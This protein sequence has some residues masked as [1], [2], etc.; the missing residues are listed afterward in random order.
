MRKNVFSFK[1]LL[2]AA[3]VIYAMASIIVWVPQID[4]LLT[5]DYDVI[6]EHIS[7][8]DGWEVIRSFTMFPWMLSI[9]R[10]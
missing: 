4:R 2:K 7:L 9:F 5:K 3:W 1:N 10:Q 6:S 8:D